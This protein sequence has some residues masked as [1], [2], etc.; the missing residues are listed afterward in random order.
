MDLNLCSKLKTSRY[1]IFHKA[2]Q[3]FYKWDL[4]RPV[5]KAARQTDIF[6]ISIPAE[7]SWQ[8]VRKI[9]MRKDVC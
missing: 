7:Y 5:V 1:K 4:G 2:R 8:Q 9:T 3:P 6:A